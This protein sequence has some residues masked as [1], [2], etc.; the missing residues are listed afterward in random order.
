MDAAIWG[1]SFWTSL[2][3]ISM[4]FPDQ[5]T[6]AEKKAH[7]VFLK[8]VA[9]ILPCS[10]CQQHFEDHLK[11]TNW[12]IALQSKKSYMIWLHDIHNKVNEV[13][14]K[15]LMNYNDMLKM[16]QSAIDQGSFNPWSLSHQNRLLKS[17][18]IVTLVL[19]AVSFWKK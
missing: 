15:P 17:A 16:Y 1:P 9:D 13:N 12:E 18:L 11:Q 19:L 5:P 4:S 14:H 7:Q 10:V 3:F 6:S 8:S 2:H